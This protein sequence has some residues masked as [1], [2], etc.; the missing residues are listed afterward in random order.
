MDEYTAAT[1]ALRARVLEVGAHLRVTR[2]KT[3]VTCAR[4]ASPARPVVVGGHQ[5]FLPP[6]EHLRGVPDRVAR[7][8]A[9]AQPR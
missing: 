4:A 1:P 8:V 7:E 3:G 2:K 6:A 9:V 5:H